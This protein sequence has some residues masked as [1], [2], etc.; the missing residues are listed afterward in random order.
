MAEGKE[1]PAGYVRYLERKKPEH[2]DDEWDEAD[3]ILDKGV[4]G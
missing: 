1:P 2:V 4:K 3:R